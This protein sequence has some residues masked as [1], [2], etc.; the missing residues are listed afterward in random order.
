MLEDIEELG[1]RGEVD[2][3]QSMMKVCDQLKE[4]REQ[5]QGQRGGVSCDKNHQNLFYC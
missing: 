3:A 1:S 2:Q 5:L 4:D